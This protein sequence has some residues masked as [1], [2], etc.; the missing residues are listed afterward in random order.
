MA[1][2]VNLERATTRVYQYH[3][4]QHDGS[5]WRFMLTT[6]P[7]AATTEYTFDKVC[8]VAFA[9]SVTGTVPVYQYHAAQHDG[10][11]YLYSLDAATPATQGW[12][13]DGLV[14]RVYKEAP[15]AGKNAAMVVAVYQYHAVTPAGWRFFYSTSNK[16]G[17]GWTLDGPCWYAF[18]PTQ[19]LD[20]VDCS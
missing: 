1:A 9:G 17:Q 19:D 5:G 10:V 18:A 16:E 11:R 12:T 14:G 8:F 6:T 7:K 3:A 2:I 20:A 4:V 15:T 13:L